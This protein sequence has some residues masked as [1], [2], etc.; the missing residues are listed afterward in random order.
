MTELYK[1][2]RPRS[3]DKVV[4]NRGTVQALQK[5]VAKGSIPHTILFSG[6]SGC[7]KTTLARILRKELGCLDTDFHE[8]NCAQNRGVDVIRDIQRLMQFAPVGKARVWLL[9]EVHQLTPE[10]Q[11]GALKMLEDTPEHVWFFLATTNPGKLRPT[12]RNRST[13]MP[14]SLLA[15]DEA[16]KLIG[17][18]AKKESLELHKHAVS[19]IVEQAGGSA[20]RVLVLLD[21][22]KD[23]A[24]DDQEEAIKAGLDEE[25]PEVIELCRALM[26]G[27]GWGKVAKILRGLKEDPEKVRWAVLGYMRAVLL[28][29]G[30][31]QTFFTIKAFET[32]F[33]DSKEAGLVA[34]CYEAV[35]GE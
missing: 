16:E 30:D 33:Y 24:K 11:E 23:L 13:D 12:I 26:G 22:V 15:D 27:G 1:K 4:G 18:V 20:R 3:L 31:K 32:P 28:S 21:K 6:P 34:A 17:Y 25:S 2:Y 19:L 14:V 29:K 9:D 10:A 7:G 8:V 35:H 5:M